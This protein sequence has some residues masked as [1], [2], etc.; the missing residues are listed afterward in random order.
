[1]APECGP[2]PR[3]IGRQ[4]QRLR[5]INRALHARFRTAPTV[6]LVLAAATAGAASL[7]FPRTEAREPCA[8]VA[9]L[10]TPFFGDLHV[11]TR[12]SADA[13]IFGTRVEPRDAYSFARG[14]PIPLCDENEDQTRSAQIDRPLD[15]AAD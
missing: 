7:P 13:Y 1:A 14:N 8:S 6:F 4:R 15:F 2:S 12:F 10:R 5:T 11:H 9:P 3:R